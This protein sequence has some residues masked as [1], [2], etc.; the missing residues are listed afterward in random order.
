M[1][2]DIANRLSLGALSPAERSD[3]T[4]SAVEV[5]KQQMAALL[6]PSEVNKN[7]AQAAQAFATAHLHEFQMSAEYLAHEIAKIEAGPAATGR[8]QLELENARE[9]NRMSAAEQ[10]VGTPTPALLKRFTGVADLGELAKSFG[11]DNLEKLL[12]AAMQAEAYMQHVRSAAGSNE[13]IKWMTLYGNY[14]KDVMAWKDIPDEA[15]WAKLSP[16]AKMQLG[17]KGIMGPRGKAQEDALQAAIAMRDQIGLK[18]WGPA[19]KTFAPLG[20]G[21]K[22]RV[23][24]PTGAGAGGA[25]IVAPSSSRGYTNQFDQPVSSFYGD[26][27]GGKYDLS[28]KLN[29]IKKKIWD[30]DIGKTIGEGGVPTT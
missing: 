6:L 29:S 30:S 14:N 2:Q 24:K 17:D 10:L 19:Y 20:D 9:A 22:V 18:V 5:Y 15:E 7:N 26:I 12:Q 1:V 27:V 4:K 8:A 28:G 23:L 21:P 25:P 13:Q 3:I 11:R 16:M